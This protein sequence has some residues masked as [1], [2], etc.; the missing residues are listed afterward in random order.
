ML[1]N[2]T[3]VE[4]AA[5]DQGWLTG[6]GEMVER[7]REFDWSKSPLG[8]SKSWSPALKT[9]LPTLLANR[10]PMLL[11]WGPDYIQFYNDAY[12]PIPGKKHPHQALGQPLRE[13]WSE[14]WSV[15]KPLVD[16]PFQGGPATWNDDILLEINR[17][18][19]VEESHF[20]I[21]YSPV[22]D[23][24]V[25]NGIGGVLATVHEI[26]EKVV[27]ERRV[28]VLR[29]LAARI[30]EARNA[31]EACAI[32]AQTLA[33]HERDVPFAILYSIDSDAAVARL[34]GVAGTVSGQAASPELVDL[35]ENPDG[36][37]PLGEA[38]RTGS[39][40]IVENLSGRFSNVPAGPWSD[41]PVSAAVIPIPSSEPQKT[42][43]V[44]VAAI[45]SRLRFDERYCDFFGLLKSQVASAI[46]NAQAYEQERER[47]ESLAE[48][49]RAKTTFFSNVSHEFRTPLTLML[50][51][52]EDTLRSE[53]LTLQDR[54]RLEVAHRNSLRLLRLV[55]TLLD[56][57][58]IE[59]GRIQ[60]SYEPTD[61]ASFTAELASVFRSAIE[62]AGLRLTVNCP[63][64]PE[65]VYVDRDMW[66]KIVLNL[67][68]NAF[69]F[70]FTGGIEVALKPSER[71]VELTVRDTGTGIPPEELSLI[72]Q[73][74]HRVKGARGRTFEGSGI[75]LALVQELA[76]LHGGAASVSSVP[77]QGST[78]S[79]VIPTGAAH[80]PADRVAPARSA[81]GA[82][83]GEAFV[84][85]AL[86]WLP[87]TEK[88]EPPRVAGVAGLEAI[89]N[90]NGEPPPRS[91]LSPVPRILVAD[92]NA[93]MRDYVCRLLKTAYDVVAVGDGA[94][95]LEELKSRRYD[96]VLTDVMM[97]RVDGVGLLR[98]IRANEHTAGLPVIM[99]SARAGQES[100][101]EGLEAGADD[102]LTKPFS[103]RELLARVETRLMLQRV[104]RDAERAVRE[105]ETRF[106]AF[107]SATSEVIY[108][109]T[110]NWSAMR[111]LE[112]R[113][114]I[115]D[116]ENPNE[117]WLDKYI[118]ADEQHR[119]MRAVR[120]AV[121]NKCNFELEHRVY[122]VDGSIGWTFSR[123]VPLED[124]EGNV[125]EW[126]GA[127]LDITERRQSQE[128][129]RRRTSQY[130]T[131]FKQAP[132]GVYLVDADFRI[133]E[134][135]P[136]ANP[137]FG[138]VPDLIGRNFE[139]VMRKLWDREY[140]DE[141]VALFRNTMETG[142]PHYV[143]ES[144]HHRID[145][146]ADEYYEWRIAR[147]PLP[148][149]RNGVV[150]YFREI[151]HQVLSRARVE[152]ALANEKRAR[153]DAEQANRLKDE[154]VATVSHELRTPLNAI[155]GWTELLQTGALDTED[156]Q[157]ALKTVE[158]NARIQNQLIEDLLDVSKI[159]T[160]KIRLNVR[161]VDLERV[162]ESTIESVRMAA[163]NK[164][165]DIESF[166][167]SRPAPVAG[168][169]MRLQQI[170]WNLLSNAIKFTH[171][172]GRVDIELKYSDSHAEI[173]IR[174]N[175][176]GIQ[177]EFLP[178]VF[179][180]FRQA[181]SSS[182]RLFGGLGLGLAIVRHLSE[183]HGGSVRADSAGPGLGATFTVLLPLMSS[184]TSPD[185]DLPPTVEELKHFRPSPV[186]TGLRVLVVDDDLDS[187]RLIAELLSRCEASVILASSSAQGLAALE[188]KAVDVILADISMPEEDG[189]TF[190]RKV[191]ARQTDPKAWIP[192]A[193]ITAHASADDRRRVLMSGYQMH[194][195]KPVDAEE[196]VVVVASLSK[197]T[198]RT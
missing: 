103:A 179:E 28:G 106:R 48:L 57:A 139:D 91:A 105:S 38:L 126:F 73:R 134:M 32:A 87:S 173:V 189:Y 88:D 99:L 191:R 136:S 69:K 98:E 169:P 53:V 195:A 96:L 52:L 133:R 130:D 160:G 125:T 14:I 119:V 178:Y 176:I 164:E 83:H 144:I 162:I 24:T 128:M 112:G 124:A 39:M 167:D 36:G 26:T 72:F 161:Q 3:P 9:I 35:R 122:R 16:T 50:A 25:P 187:R 166:V 84:E 95:A 180:R 117:G 142:E 138:N 10:F 127:A 49:D 29:D 31:D 7:T 71:S 188:D 51:P 41:P 1:M 17:H 145:R 23:E 46:A 21:A 82:S 42:A 92:D 62:R 5:Q 12:S 43:A 86:R 22:P 165:I 64:L 37:W 186:L 80:L 129:L 2:E 19:F 66:E 141:L 63:H 190:I 177:Q 58:R 158:R 18:G 85:E 163:E 183:L 116:T 78:F 77:G 67:I 147:I 140:A 68:S 175:G 172:G 102:Y 44:L 108:S 15:L 47:A 45:S 154:F 181:D 113:N 6:Q 185:S 93:D 151:S 168:D 170:L 184:S 118:P 74:F 193:A 8:S 30:G 60:A 107:A 40:L 90:R 198:W 157:Q 174:D 132:W 54:E 27:A 109:M 110:P 152:Q 197:L 148:E 61:L 104:R 75:G 123:A 192:A 89:P 70:T 76:K 196:L 94:A 13:C 55:N 159:V 100:R 156:E 97:P 153:E 146:H 120:N 111:H 131:L 81:H 59:A 56:F 171:R 155:L 4:G 115:A 194:V 135:N 114:F 79:V 101:V 182:T 121:A 33:G 143:E 11:W 65:E 150:C 137:Y 149:G 34:V 20:T